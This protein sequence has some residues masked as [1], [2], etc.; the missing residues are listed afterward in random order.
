MT[1]TFTATKRSESVRGDDTER[2]MPETTA[3]GVVLDV[4]AHEEGKVVA[5][6]RQQVAQFHAEM[7]ELAEGE[8][9]VMMTWI[10]GVSATVSEMRSRTWDLRVRGAAQLRERQIDPLA[11]ELQFQFGVASRRLEA[12][13]VQVGLTRG[14]T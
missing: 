7:R 6:F 13:K 10:A 11:S 14:M 2:L 1:Q 3:V 8:P 9:D 12:V 5:L 4:P